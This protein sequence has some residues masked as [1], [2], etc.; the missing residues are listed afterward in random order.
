MARRPSGTIRFRHGIYDVRI[1]LGPNERPCFALPTCKTEAEA[2]ARALVLSGIAER[3]R[4]AGH[5]D[6]AP[7]F[8]ERAAARDGKALD[9]VIEAVDRL[10]AGKVAVP[11]KVATTFREFAEEWT[12]GKLH[13][14]WPDHVKAK[15]TADDD[16]MRLEKHVYPIV[17]HVPLAE[18][19]LDHGDAVMRA[20]PDSLSRASRRHIAQTIH[21]V[22]AL[23]V[24][25]ARIIDSNPLPRGFLPAAGKPKAKSYIYPD[26]DRKL[27][28]TTSI[29]IVFRVLY[30][31]MARE[32]MRREEAA[33][34]RWCQIDLE[35]G[36]VRLDRTKTDEA[37]AWALDAGVVRALAAWRELR[38]GDD[39][40]ELVFA[41]EDGRRLNV[42]HL[43]EQLRRHLVEAGVKRAEL[44]EHSKTRQRMRAHDLRATFITVSLANGK[45]ERWVTDRTGHTSSG[46]VSRYQ[47]VARSH[48]EL[49][50]GALAPLDNAIPEL[51][52]PQSV[53]ESVRSEEEREELA[54]QERET[55]SECE[56]RDSNP[57]ALRR[58]NLNQINEDS[59]AQSSVISQVDD[60]PID[61]FGAT[62]TDSGPIANPR[63]RL[64]ADLSQRM[65]EAALAGDL[66]AARICHETIAKLLGDPPSGGADV[67]SIRRKS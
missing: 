18:F 56:K 5:A 39:A 14:R 48:E 32:G 55:K 52:G 7:R 49:G 24:Y 60:P 3:L 29:P 40:P 64:I 43:A 57:H 25:P 1:T 19:S 4:A 45:S 26:E 23:A 31:F 22:L 9:D 15:R 21:R 13:A 6:L 46:Q 35:R 47:R 30:G 42:E 17:G 61:A 10:C 44:F 66:E 27:L 54:S 33:A 53:R 51:R 8:L 63:A 11:A 20:L 62:R 36:S 50:L 2:K 16:R 38:G 41:T 37:R 58:R 65:T 28:A 67:V 59:L 34:L 12:K